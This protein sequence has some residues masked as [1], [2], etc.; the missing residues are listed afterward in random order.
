MALRVWVKSGIGRWLAPL[1]A[2]LIA[3][4]LAAPVAALGAEGTVRGTEM[5][6]YG[7]AVFSF[8]ALPKTQMRTS[9]G[10]LILSFDRPVS[11]NVDKLPVELPS[12]VSAARLDPD[13]RGLR[14]ALARPL[15]PNQLEAGEKLFIDFL[16]ESW[17][18][19]PPGLPQDV[20][21]DL[22]RRAREAEEAARKLLRMKAAEEVK[23]L[24]FRVGTTPT[25]TR[26]VFQMPV[27]SP[28][29]FRRDGDTVELQF[30][31]S[32]RIDVARLKSQLPDTVASVEAEAETGLLRIVMQIPATLDVRGFREDNTF[33][34]DIPTPRAA[35][36]VAGKAEPKSEPKAGPQGKSAAA[37]PEA[38]PESAGRPLVE[39]KP[40]APAAEPPPAAPTPSTKVVVPPP[41][42]RIG[43]D[44]PPQQA[45]APV[46]AEVQI[47]ATA[48]RGSL[49][50]TL[51]LPTSIPIAV[52]E[53]AGTLWIAAETDSSLDASRIG[54]VAPGVVS[55]AEMRRVGRLAVLRLAMTG[56]QLVRAAATDAGWVVT[57]GNDVAAPSQPLGFVRDAD[58]DGRTVLRA[59]FSD[60]GGVHWVDD[61]EVGDKLAIVTGRT[62]VHSL[63]KPLSF[64]DFRALATAQGLALAPVSDD[65]VVRAGIDDV[66][67][68]RDGGL[69]ISLLV[70]APTPVKGAPERPS[71][72]D[73]DKWER[74]RAGNVRERGREL[75]RAAADAPKRSR[76]EARLAVA[77]FE[78]ANRFAVEAIGTLDVAMTDD[79]DITREKA[80]IVLNGVAHAL[81]GRNAEAV[82]ILSGEDLKDE[83]EAQLWRGFA[84]A[85]MRRWPQAL[86]AF[87]RSGTVLSGYP[88]DLQGQIAPWYAEAAIEARDF[89]LAQRVLESIEGLS[90]EVVDRQLVSFLAARVAEGQGR[91]EDAFAA[92]DKLAKTAKRPVEARARLAG[93]Q[94]AL[95]DRT[96]DRKAAIGELEG[97]AVSWRGD[98]VEARSLSL[99]GRLYA[100]E[101]RWRDAFTMARRANELFPDSDITRALYDETGSKFEALFLENKGESIPRLDAVALY[102]DFKDFTPPGRRGD[103]MIRRLAE[104]LVQLDLLTEAGDL[105]QHQV[106]N[107]LSG[108]AKATV[109]ARLAVI[110]L[111]NRQPGKAYQALRDSRLAELPAELKRSRA[112][113]EARALSDLSRTDL[114]LELIAAEEGP[115]VER[116]RADVLWQARRWRDAGDVYERIVGDAWKKTEPLDDRARADVMRAAIAFG[117]ADDMLSLERLRAKFAAKMADSLDV[118]AFS[119]VTAPTGARAS[120]YRE[121]A[122][123]IASADTLSEFLTEY[124]KRYPDA[125]APTRPAAPPAGG[126]TD[127]GASNAAAPATPRAPG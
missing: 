53:R 126:S 67:V 11:I 42:P 69:A 119:V 28:V 113:L 117:L 48:E 6:G 78:L 64:V 101:G 114:A 57:L 122:R 65:L 123:S 41:A 95:R 15:K 76:P 94:L 9:N 55:S 103:E 90:P 63:I 31:N 43:S 106:D 14:M 108:A 74:D 20:I 73:R 66:T 4:A 111:M 88:D 116:L 45:A 47:E 35:A 61:P 84:E 12:Y 40:A 54:L 85:Q 25:F 91:L 99:L 97:I 87:R 89:G 2:G 29:E 115:E 3:L 100:E 22:S 17:R 92:Y 7:R 58:Q 118:R 98:D 83:P 105:L 51:P 49:R 112:L 21:D 121:L 59:P 110:H 81:A 56:Q 68:T 10:I 5:N 120:E 71:A 8:D 102:F 39:G 124:R 38:S 46:P 27:V 44:R 70:D 32:F 37:T 60:V 62:T 33:A 1:R 127:Q 36:K 24:T 23:D 52:F 80:V 79:P 77:R 19:P 72:I 125:G 18:Q 13:G 93:I 50:L 34:I 104:R 75:M 82:K 109:A 107:R 30:Q 26:V 16:P 86:V 96:I